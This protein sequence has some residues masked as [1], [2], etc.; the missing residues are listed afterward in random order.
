MRLKMG[1]TA[2]AVE[3]WGAE[4]QRVTVSEHYGVLGGHVWRQVI[5]GKWAGPRLAIGATPRGSS[6]DALR[7]AWDRAWLRGALPSPLLDAHA[8]VR[9]PLRVVDLSAG[10]GA[11]SLGLKM[12]GEA[13]GMPF[14]PLLS[15]DF[16]ASALDVYRQNLRPAET[17]RDDLSD[18]IEYSLGPDGSS[19]AVEPRLL[20]PRF[21]ALAGNIDV[22][23]GGPPCQGHSDLNN[24]SRRDDP[25]NSLYLLM[26]AFASAL[27]PAVVIIENVP[28]VVH[29]KLQVVDKSKALLKGLGYSV[30]SAPISMEEIGIAQRRRRHVLVATRNGEVALDGVLKAFAT[31]PRSAAWAIGDLVN[32]ESSSTFNTASTQN[33]VNKKRIAWLFENDQYDL[34][35]TERPDCHK[36]G[37]H[38]YRS[39]YGRMR[40]TEPA[41]T[42]T[43]GFGSPGQGRYIHP[44]TQRTITPHEAARL[45]YFPDSFI[46]RADDDEPP[47]TKL[48][49]MIGNAVPPKL[50]YVVGVAAI[51]TALGPEFARLR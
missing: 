25:K 30:A 11:M 7:S 46:F 9:R 13:L 24:H 27:A 2:E 51:A 3:N 39:M 49:V 41:Q 4:P 22:L 18:A 8:V 32:S 35:N 37:G 17:Y 1:Q 48:A 23:I 36:Y 5:A 20:D 34:P 21:Q 10:C 19:F 14:A 15:A 28:A 12:A 42:I 26:A 47:R 43:S 16:E 45:Q 40:W 44:R 6:P 33:D 50:T 38:S 31:R 29:D